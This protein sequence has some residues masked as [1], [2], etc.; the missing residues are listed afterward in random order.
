M[1]LENLHQTPSRPTALLAT[2][3]SQWHYVLGHANVCTIKSI[4]HHFNIP[5]HSDNNACHA[6]NVSKS[7]KLP[8]SLSS[9]STSKPLELFSSDVWGPAPVQSIDSFKYYVLF[10]II[11]TSIVGFIL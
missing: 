4:L 5:F 8:F 3:L 11:T 2:P 6:C 1:I 10:F 7:H 9:S